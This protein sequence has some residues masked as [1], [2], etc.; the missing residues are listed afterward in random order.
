MKK[1]SRA[2]V[3]LI[4]KQKGKL[5]IKFLLGRG[6]KKPEIYSLWVAKKSVLR[7]SGLLPKGLIY[8]EFLEQ[9]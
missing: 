8:I 4:Q 2:P 3:Y 9:Q 1:Y 6:D 7:V 5:E